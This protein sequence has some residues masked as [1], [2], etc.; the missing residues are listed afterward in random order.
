MEYITKKQSAKLDELMTKRFHIS[1]EMMMEIAGYKIAEFIRDNFREREIL[2]VVGKG[3]NA[4]D[5][6][7]TARHLSNFGFSV[8]IY[9]TSPELC[10]KSLKHL[11]IA[12]TLGIPFVNTIEKHNLVLDCIFGYNLKGKPNEPFNTAIELINKNKKIISCDIPSGIDSNE[13]II[14]EPYVKA[15]HILFLGMPKIG[16]KEIKAKKFVADIGV[17][18][19]LYPLIELEEKNHFTK[20]GIIRLPE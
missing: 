11:R 17:P 14:H 4:G 10:E 7:C 18:K 6:L 13:G 20:K 16:C 15:T 19:K 8:N 9:L 5:G 1:A 3:N 2:I 12:K